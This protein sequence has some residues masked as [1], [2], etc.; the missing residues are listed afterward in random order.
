MFV[1]CSENSAT[2]LANKA[3]P[4]TEVSSI[5][6]ALPLEVSFVFIFNILRKLKEHTLYVPVTQSLPEDLAITMETH[7]WAL[8]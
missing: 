3:F 1:S 5:H 4:A 8:R 7:Y 2:Q 6:G